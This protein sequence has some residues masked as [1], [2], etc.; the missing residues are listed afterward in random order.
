M[1]EG[2]NY[3]YQSYVCAAIL[4]RRIRD[5]STLSSPPSSRKPSID[6]ASTIAPFA[7]PSTADIVACYASRFYRFL[8]CIVFKVITRSGLRKTLSDKS[9]IF[10]RWCKFSPTKTKMLSKLKWSWNLYLSPEIINLKEFL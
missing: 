3:S 9:E 2:K 6:L 1:K 7:A 4:E 5:T 8:W 10:F